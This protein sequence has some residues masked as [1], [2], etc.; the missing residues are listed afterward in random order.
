MRK[1]EDELRSLRRRRSPTRT[2]RRSTRRSV[3][4]DPIVGV[5]ASKAFP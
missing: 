5:P 4:Q 3:E 1:E 2:G